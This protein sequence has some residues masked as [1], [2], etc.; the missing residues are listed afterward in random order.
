MHLKLQS[1]A[2][3]WAWQAV[4]VPNE[5]KNVNSEWI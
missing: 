2:G 5:E 3:L 1:K 4:A